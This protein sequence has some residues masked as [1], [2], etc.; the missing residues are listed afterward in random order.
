MALEPVQPVPTAE[1]NDEGRRDAA[2]LARGVCR[3]LEDR[4]FGALTEFSLINGRRADVIAM[5]GAGRFVIVEIKTSEADFRADKKWPD[6]REFC[7]LFYFAVPV[8]FP[9]H[10]IPDD[11]GL[12]IADAYGAAVLRESGESA[13]HPSR[14]KALLLRFAL[15]ATSRLQQFTAPRL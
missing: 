7:D 14:R 10:L 8:E 9:Q 15:T 1:L 11:C 13:M 12:L 2:Q 5:D 4:G 6:Y 3:A